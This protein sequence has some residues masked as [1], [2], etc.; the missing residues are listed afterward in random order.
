ML[1]A[2]TRQHPSRSPTVPS[3]SNGTQQRLLS[4]RSPTPTPRA[5]SAP[6]RRRPEP[7]RGR[8]RYTTTSS[9]ETPSEGVDPRFAARYLRTDDSLTFAFNGRRAFVQSIAGGAAHADLTAAALAI[10][11]EDDGLG[12]PCPRLC[13]FH[14]DRHILFPDGA[15]FRVPASFVFVGAGAA[16]CLASA[17]V[18]WLACVLL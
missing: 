18:S 2:A 17:L 9:G 12:A 16:L 1:P 11:A 6:R 10:A 8:E 3:R 7:P 4:N 15:F 14:V 13:L 5:T